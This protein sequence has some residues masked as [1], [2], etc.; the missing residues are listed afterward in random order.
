MS[1]ALTEVPEREDGILR[2]FSID[3]QAP[4]GAA[5]RDA[6]L[7]ESAE[8]GPR[9]A[10]AL[11]LR[12]LDPWWVTHLRMQ[13]IAE[14]G[15]ASFL[16]EGYGVSGDQLAAA[17][18]ALDRADG[19]LML[20]QSPAFEGRAANLAPA[21]HVAPLA[22]FDTKGRPA[23]ARPMAKA[24]VAPVSRQPEAPERSAAEGGGGL[25]PVALLAILAIAALLVGLAA[26]AE[27]ADGV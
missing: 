3:T 2:L 24:E 20:V 26:F 27:L 11:G 9:A 23:P 6:I 5:L 8:A 12:S 16:S 18:D 1:A 21:G 15:L 10:A 13:D 17:S 7:A 22:A 19:S 4:D 25:R 14:L